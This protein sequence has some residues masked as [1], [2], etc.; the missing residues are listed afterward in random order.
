[1]RLEVLM[2]AFAA[3]SAHGPA[4]SRETVSSEWTEVRI[5]GARLTVERITPAPADY[6]N[7]T[8]ILEL[9]GRRLRGKEAMRALMDEKQLAEP[10][11]LAQLSELF[12]DPVGGRIISTPAEAES[13]PAAPRVKPPAVHAGTL[14][15]WAWT[16]GMAHDVER[17]R[18]DLKTLVRETKNAHA[19][20]LDENPLGIARRSLAAPGDLGHRGG[21]DLLVT[22]CAREGA[23]AL[24]AETLRTHGSIETRAYA[25]WAVRKCHDRATIV[26]VLIEALEQDTALE[27]R[28][29]VTETM[30]ELGVLAAP[31]LPLL[32]KL[33]A[34][35][36]G[37]SL[38]HI[39]KRA[40]GKIE[41]A[42]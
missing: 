15:Y 40:V 41:K 5:P 2:V 9:G 38:N 33:A 17:V 12:L 27:V 7:R 21:I 6:D 20:A 16:G 30:G 22:Y 8:A 34:T 10:M 32:E 19:F 37:D 11:I 28:A 23:P 42:K 13:D 4:K 39:A 18:V 3:C 14:E 25:A 35:D 26:A 1:M 31:A 24:L 36:A 29:A